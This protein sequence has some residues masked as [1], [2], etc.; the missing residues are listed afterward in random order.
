MSAVQSLLLRRIT[1]DPQVRFGKPC[2][3]GHRITVQE[4]LEWAL[5]WCFPTANPG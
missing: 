5:E 3:R 2:I 1:T 4:V